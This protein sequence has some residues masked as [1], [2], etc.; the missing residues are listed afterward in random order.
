MKGKY[1]LPSGMYYVYDV[2]GGSKCGIPYL[3]LRLPRVRKYFFNIQK[4]SRS[5]IFFSLLL[6]VFLVSAGKELFKDA[7]CNL[8]SIIFL[9]CFICAKC[10]AAYLF[11][12]EKYT[13]FYHNQRTERNNFI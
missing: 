4:A 12:N 2:D 10:F 5:C 13:I 6:V 1:C 9:G 11:T 7:L 8:C 3:V